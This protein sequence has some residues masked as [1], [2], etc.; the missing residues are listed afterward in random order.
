VS[1]EEGAAAALGEVGD[2]GASDSSSIC[3]QNTVSKL[4]NGKLIFTD[5]FCATVVHRKSTF[6]LAFFELKPH[7]LT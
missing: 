3:Q 6:L 4:K 1:G 2:N 7:S 5:I